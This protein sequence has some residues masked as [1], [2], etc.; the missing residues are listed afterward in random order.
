MLCFGNYKVTASS[1]KHLEG[2]SHADI[3]WLIYK[4]LTSSR[5]SDDMSIDFDRDR[6][7][8]Q[9]ELKIY[10]DIKGKYHIRCY[11]KNNFVYVD[12]QEKATHGSGQKLTLMR[13]KR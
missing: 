9:K 5:G 6:G 11:L 7:R 13:Y 4:L 3:V 8:R 10:K 1:G 12:H 2:F